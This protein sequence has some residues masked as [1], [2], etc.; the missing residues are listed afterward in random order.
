MREQ[1]RLSEQSPEISLRPTSAEPKPEY[2][3]RK[4]E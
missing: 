4:M 1:E 3:V 2:P